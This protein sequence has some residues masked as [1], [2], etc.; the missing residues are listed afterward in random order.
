MCEQLES[1]Y[2][3]L[4]NIGSIEELKLY[5]ADGIDV[6]QPS[7]SKAPT[8]V[9][10]MDSGGNV[11]E[12]SGG[13]EASVG[14]G[15]SGDS[16]EPN[17]N[18][19]EVRDT[20]ESSTNS[21]KEDDPTQEAAKEVRDKCQIH[22][23]TSKHIKEVKAAENSTPEVVEDAR[24]ARA[25]ASVEHRRA[26]YE[27][28]AAEQAKKDAIT[29]AGLDINSEYTPEI[30]EGELDSASDLDNSDLETYSESDNDYGDPADKKADA[31]DSPSNSEGK[32]GHKRS[33]SDSVDD[34]SNKK[35]KSD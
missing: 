7:P 29:K 13:N 27:Y 5:A 21:T 2:H 34:S 35:I 33:A 28:Y 9:L 3:D 14:S 15:A 18:N 6:D 17:N 1:I 8:N 26:K 31:G 19:P 32:S 4:C 11:P 12:G 22:K 16:R 24:E 23:E 25:K 20:V 10:L 30:Q